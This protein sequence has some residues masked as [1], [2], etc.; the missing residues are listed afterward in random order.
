MTMAGGRAMEAPG[1]ATFLKGMGGTAAALPLLPMATAGA[2]RA[3]HPAG[4]SMRFAH[5]TDLHFTNRRQNRYPT[6]H[7]RARS[8]T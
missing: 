7:P 2:G 8:R 1:A 5:V 4:S 6:S 3:H